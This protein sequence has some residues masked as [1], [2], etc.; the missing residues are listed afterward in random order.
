[1][2]SSL[3]ISLKL[4]V[5]ATIVLGFG[6]T[7]CTAES[8]S[9][10]GVP[11][12]SEE[13]E[14]SDEEVPIFSIPWGRYEW[15]PVDGLPNAVWSGTLVIDESCIY[16][17]VSHIFDDSYHQDGYTIPEGE[18]LRGCLNLPEPLTQLNATTGEL[19]LGEHGPMS[20]GDEVVVVGSGRSQQY[21]NSDLDASTE[22]F[23]VYNHP[24]NISEDGEYQEIGCVADVH[25]YVMSMQSS[26]SYNE[27][28]ALDITRSQLLA[29]LSWDMPGFRDSVGMNLILAIEPPCVYGVPLT[30][31]G[32][33]YKDEDFDR[34]VIRLHRPLVRFKA[35]TNSLWN[36]YYLWTGN[37]G[38]MTTGDIVT[39]YGVDHPADAVPLN[40]DL[41]EA[42]CSADGLLLSAGL[43]PGW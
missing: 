32:E 7:G 12:H 28:P 15:V 8:E 42:G 30:D 13:P 21:W 36:N 39:V 4:M 40:S 24:D 31:S 35:D 23:E 26:D 14:S 33:P 27:K 10:S 9:S 43:T 6:V 3:Q 25:F 34:L 11:Q 5:A 37:L 20:N 16:L 41:Q 1:M 22:F 38:P 29:G 19:W 2:A 17:D 18:A